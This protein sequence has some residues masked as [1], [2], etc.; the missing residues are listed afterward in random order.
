VTRHVLLLDDAKTVLFAFSR[1]LRAAGFEVDRARELE[2]AEAL[3]LHT[4]YDLVISD[5][6]LTGSDG[7]E[8][9]EFLRFLRRH[10]PA[11]RVILLTAYLSALVAR[12]A[13]ALGAIA[14]L[15]KTRPLPEIAE[16]AVGLC[17]GAPRA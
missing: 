11:V 6:S 9:L 1:L 7:H 13:T 14:C 2:E 15:E 8:G 4:R 5:L 10:C 16:L 3:A 17:Q 12:E